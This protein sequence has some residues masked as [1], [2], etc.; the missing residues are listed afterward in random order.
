[1]NDDVS[2]EQTVNFATETETHCR[3]QEVWKKIWY[4]IYFY[5]SNMHRLALLMCNDLSLDLI[6]PA[7]I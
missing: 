5:K 7:L 6:I 2:T 3:G 1:M 4:K